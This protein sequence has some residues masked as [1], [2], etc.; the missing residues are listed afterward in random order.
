M[1]KTFKGIDVSVWQGSINFEKVKLN[2]IDF[3]IIKAGGSDDDFYTDSCF[4][5][6]YNN[7][8]K[9]G[10]KIGCY[11]IVGSNFDTIEKGTKNAE[12]F[13]KIIK[14]K[15]FDYPI[16][17]DLELTSPSQK[18]GATTA[19]IAFCDYLISHGY[20]TGI[21]GSSISGFKD[22]LD[23]NRLGKYDKWVAQYDLEKPTYPPNCKIWQYSSTGRIDGINCNVDMNISY[24]DYPS[25]IKNSTFSTNVSTSVKGIQN[26]LNANYKTD[27][28]VDGILSDLTEKALVK[29]LQTELNKQY[30][31]NLDIDGIFGDKTKTEIL[32]IFNATKDSM[33]KILQGLVI[34]NE[35]SANIST[36]VN[37]D[38][39]S[40]QKWL[41]VNYKS[42]LIVDGIFGD[43]TKKALV[44]ALQT[45][46]NKQ[47]N[48]NLAIDGIF[49]EKTKTEIP[50]V[51]FGASGNI[52]K[53]LQGLLICNGYTLNG[54][55]GIFGSGTECA[56]ISYQSNQSL[57][58]DGIAGEETFFSLC[59]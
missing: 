10:L 34:C 39:E 9:A 4:E 56:V 3:V 30:N 37:S 44:K 50:E 16:F 35:Y 15:T 46:L 8:K 42:D 29:A 33:T 23:I 24:C 2:G 47:Y 19:S 43:L 40:V 57:S 7:A 58:I 11:Y 21:Y 22:R 13:A 25:I 18:Y 17:L 41:N 14:G 52:T 31:S 49:G 20:Y 45:E 54:F 48:S 32:N 12:H 51:A 36:S 28:I 1:T 55:D 53:I 59:K 6:N 5:I 26:W 38:I 27:L